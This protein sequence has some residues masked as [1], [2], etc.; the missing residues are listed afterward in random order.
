MSSKRA[1]SAND[2]ELVAEII[3]QAGDPGTA[4]QILFEQ[5]DKRKLNAAEKEAV[6]RWRQD[7]YDQI[8]ERVD[9]IPNTT[10]GDV[11]RGD[12]RLP[13]ATDEEKI[14][15]AGWRRQRRQAVQVDTPSKRFD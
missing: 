7:L 4:S 15:L 3:R 5:S 1:A 14:F 9:A 12:R 2:R 8:L 13:A 10:V 6:A 11:L